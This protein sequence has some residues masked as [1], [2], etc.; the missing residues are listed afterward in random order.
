MNAAAGTVP[1]LSRPCLMTEGPTTATFDLAI[2]VGD[3]VR[4]LGRIVNVLALLDL[5]PLELFVIASQ[6][7]LEVR[8]S[9][10][11]ERRAVTLALQRLAAL[12]CVRDAQ[13][14]A[15]PGAPMSGNRP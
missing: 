9:V 10:M 13:L 1:D 3:G 15:K 14:R 11:A 12:P 2:R 8:A 7:D 4:G 5:T 6:G